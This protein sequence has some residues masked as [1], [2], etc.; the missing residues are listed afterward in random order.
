[1]KIMWI[2]NTVIG[3]MYEKIYQKKSNGLWMDALLKSF[4]ENN[5]HQLIVVTTGRNKDVIFFEKQNVKYYILPGGYPIEYKYRNKKN[6]KWWA[7]LIENEK[8][9]II[10]LWGTEFQHGLAAL[11]ACKKIPSVIYMQGLPGSVYKYYYAGLK[12]SEIIKNITLRD[13]LRHD[14]IIDQKNR[15]SKQVKYEKKILE[16]SGNIISENFWCDTQCRAIAPDIKIYRCPL[17]I[18]EVFTKYK[19]EYDKIVKYT[20]MCNASGYPLKGLH[21]ILKAVSRIKNKYPDIK[22]VVPG[23]TMVTDNTLSAKLRR[24]GYVKYIEKQI[25]TLNIKENIEFTGMLSSEEMALK[26]STANVFVMGSVIENHSSTL[27]EAMTVGVPCVASMVGGI[28][29]YAKHEYNSLLYRYEDD[30]MLAQYIINIIENK[31]LAESLSEHAVETSVEVNNSCTIYKNIIGI[32]NKII[33]G[34]RK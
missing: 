13:I 3:D 27:K 7:G 17:S 16:Q 24:K 23:E 6:N 11:D 15:F 10:Q 25:E 30:I 31:T 2:T 12:Y 34:D 33:E 20:V 26:L 1:M 32:Y 22:L 18:N 29:E 21:I 19:W 9:D 4:I 14:S 5:Q 8:P 28:Q